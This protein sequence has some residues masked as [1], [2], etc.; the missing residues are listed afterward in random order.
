MLEVKDLVENNENDISVVPD[1]GQYEYITDEGSPSQFL[2][3]DSL[4]GSV[5]ITPKHIIR[6]EF[7]RTALKGFTCLFYFGIMYASWR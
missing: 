2:Q 4:E 3:L 5:T 1:P 6:V 7:L